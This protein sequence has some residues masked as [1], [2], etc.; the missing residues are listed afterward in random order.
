[1]RGRTLRIALLVFFVSTLAGV[2]FATQLNLAYPDYE[3]QSWPR[4]LAI[5]LMQYWMWGA[6]VP[7]VVLLGRR[8]RFES[9]GWATVPIHLIASVAVTIVQLL[10][11]VV[12]LNLVLPPPPFTLGYV[13]INFHSSL[14]TYWLILFVYWAADYSGRAAR[15]KASLTEARLDV[16]TMQLNPH[17]LFNTL[18][19]I[20]SLMYSDT[21]AADRMMTRLS[22]LLRST[23]HNNG[24]QEVTLGEELEFVDRY[25]EI[26]KIR[27]DERLR[28][29]VHADP[30]AL[31]GLV[32]AFSLQPLVE[33]SLR[34]G[35]GPREAG[36]SL[37]I[38]A[39]RADGRLLVRIA[40]DGL[41]AADN[42]V[43]EGV[44]LRNTRSR[45]AALYDGLAR[46]DVG[47]AGGGGF[48]VQL[49]LPFR[50]PDG[51]RR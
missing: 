50:R 6:L 42:P 38:E 11:V 35:I 37:S 19:S 12:A 51:G 22:E 33:N 7:L 4:A 17:F 49:D 27:F 40:D 44:G 15:L 28:V 5:N 3:R 1:M 41:G 21:E 39:R 31:D 2:Y 8:F 24:A 26:E 47:N 13:R 25:L 45:L 23:I 9:R 36:G 14:P 34:H 43:R 18:N 20:S 46:L 10:A 29:S 16:L 30:D 32:P 48:V